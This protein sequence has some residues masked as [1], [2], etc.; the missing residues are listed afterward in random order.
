MNRKFT[1]TE[2]PFPAIKWKSMIF[3]I[4]LSIFCAFA[5]YA[6]L[7]VM[8]EAIRYFSV[9]DKQDI[10]VLSDT[11]VR[12][13]NLF[14]AYLSLIFA[15]SVCISRW[16][17]SLRKPFEKRNRCKLSV[18]NN[19]RF[20]NFF[21]LHW[22]SQL[23]WSYALFI[24]ILTNGFY[25]FSLYPKYNFLFI[26]MLIVLFL[27][28][29]I[30]L[31]RACKRKAFK[32]MFCS[33]VLISVFAFA[34]S[35][36]HFVNYQK[37]N[38]NIL[39]KNISYKYNLQLAEVNVFEENHHRYSYDIHLVRTL[40]STKLEDLLIVDESAKLFFGNEELSFL[41]LK[42]NLLEYKDYEENEAMVL[43][44]NIDKSIRMADVNRL[45]SAMIDAGIQ[46]VAYSVIPKNRAY[47]QRYYTDCYSLWH[48]VRREEY[49]NADLKDFELFSVRYSGDSLQINGRTCPRKDFYSKIKQAVEKQDN[50]LMLFSVNENMIFGD[51][52]FVL[53]E[54]KRAVN[55]IRNEYAMKNYS[56]EYAELEVEKAKIVQRK[57][58]LRLIE[59]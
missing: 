5:F 57:I 47:D 21:F 20:L 49:E 19:Q 55:A 17:G 44:L 10:W 15:Q 59:K 39:D 46:G 30:S 53:T 4:V 31:L 11:E 58:P 26:L 16:F 13:Y 37:I 33:A 38:K 9:M 40:Y 18:Q 43:R 8:R 52:I 22:F 41:E 12:F 36:I 34:F 27:N 24:G 1:N 29:W 14:F 23:A 35:S 48:L 3:S 45:K 25:V 50:Y 28:T 56:A 51:Y 6:F 7:C 2:P 32:L 54:Y 42:N